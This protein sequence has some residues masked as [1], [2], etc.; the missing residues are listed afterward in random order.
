MVMHLTAPNRRVSRRLSSFGGLIA[1]LL[2]A[3]PVSAQTGSVTG[4]V[5]DKLGRQ[6]LNGVQVSIEGT[7][8]GGLTDAR[9]RFTIAGVPAGQLTVRAVYIGYRTESQQVT[10]VAGQAAAV[11]FELGVS[12]VSL[13][14]VVI[15]G[16][17]STG[18]AKREL[19]ASVSTINPGAIQEKMG[20]ITDVSTVL[21]SRIAGVRSVGTVG[22]VGTSK[23]LR[24]RGTSSFELGQ[25][26]LVYIDGVKIDTRQ[27]EWNGMGTSCCSF[28]GGAGTDRLHDL[29]P[30]DIE[31]IEVIK[32]A[33]AGT[34][35]GTE[36]T[37]GVIQIF[38]KKGRS[39]SAPR[40]SAQL[41]SGLQRNRANFQT[42]EWP[43]FQGPDGTRALDANKTLI[44]NGPYTGADLTIQG[45]G[46]TMTYFVSGGYTDEQGSIQPNW[47]KRGNLR[48]NMHWIATQKLSFEVSSAYTRNRILELQSG[49]NW[50]S[51]LGNAVLGVPYN[52]CR[53]DCADGIERPYGEPWV[54]IA[55]IRKIDTFD[56]A[57]RWTGGV[58]ANYSVRPNFINK[59]QVGLDAVNE[60]KY[61]LRPFGYP[62]TYV[63]NGEKDLGY[64]NYRSVTAE[65]LGTLNFNNVLPNLSTAVSFG[66][67][68]FQTV[69]RFNMAVGA[70]FAAPGVTTVNGGAIRSGD[71]R[72]EERVQLG[73]FGQNRL[74]F[75][76][77]IYLTTGIRVDGNSAF[78][79]D[80]GYQV[81]PNTQ[82]SYDLSQENWMPALF[83]NLR[84]R[85]AVGT[86]GLAPGAFDKFLTFEPLTTGDEE[87]GVTV[88]SQGNSELGPERTTEFEAGFEAGFWNDRIGLDLTVYRRNTKDAIVRIA[89]A[90]SL[91]FG[92]PPREN[93]GGVLDQ[94]Y[95]VALRVTPVESSRLRWST[96]LRL[97]GNHNEITDLGTVLNS[98]GELVPAMKRGDLRVGYPILTRFARVL[99]TEKYSQY[100]PG[101]PRNGG[102]SRLVNG[103][104]VRRTPYNPTTRQFTR[105]DTTV[106]IGK[107]LPDFNAS[108]GNEFTFGAFR[109]YALVTLERGAF[110][111]NSDRPYRANNR[112]GPDYLSALAEAGSPDCVTSWPTGEQGPRFV[113]TGKKWCD[114]VKSD[115]IYQMWRVVSPQDSR[116]NIRIRELSVGYQVPEWISSKVGVSGTQITL[117]AQNVQWWDNC[118]CM[119]PNM[120]YLGGSDLSVASGF[121]GQPQARMFKLS[122]RTSFGGGSSP[123]AIQG[124]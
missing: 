31:R 120:N 16:T 30:N 18:A 73:F 122:V 9:G 108:L 86:A 42:T 33:A 38:T 20:G 48:M 117:A 43:R 94:G 97:D 28:S 71:E 27:R 36:A 66:A 41:T 11:N 65:Y 13:D 77:K 100:D 59:F 54:P 109:L 7:Q 45:G 75:R 61:Y 89:R 85:A 83:S 69:E 111:N 12:A 6:P 80:Y 81:Y 84:V 51:L 78:G 112:S 15:T 2:L 70:N 123:V 72:F 44:E 114:T 64:R 116:D 88:D 101:D 87:A 118:H 124:R 26:P 90:P 19:G 93:I 119:D 23:D 25:R 47:M 21:Q 104:I 96:D 98:A 55:A 115:S 68:G 35:Y 102:C 92:D 32:G 22:G 56:D 63:P 52:A 67:Q 8:R 17:A 99:C 62:Y 95:E 53:T 24:I 3:G 110:F 103:Q 4:T 58:T 1:S 105:T 82:L 107:A 79:E 74:S 37:N 14:E 5:V 113:D 91:A 40:W 60:E 106:Y 46:N 34:L 39:E 29:N 49:N 121:L 57:N 10:V 76:D 50:T